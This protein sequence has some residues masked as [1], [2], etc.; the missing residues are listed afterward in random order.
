MS[1]VA[2]PSENKSGPVPAVLVGDP[3]VT[4]RGV[5]V[6]Q[7]WWGMN[8]QIQDEAKQIAAMGPFV[9][10]VPDLYRGKVATDNEHA[11][12]LMSNLDWP[13]AVKDI[14]ACVRYLRQRG[15]TK[16]GVTGFCMGGALTLAAA[17][18]VPGVDAAAPFYGIPSPDLCDVSKIAVPVQCH[19]GDND[20]V[21]GFS[22]PESQEKLK[23]KL[24]CQYEFHVYK[25]AGHAFTNETGPNYHP[26]NCKLSFQRLVKFFQTHL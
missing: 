17:A 21:M 20:Q 1:K 9:A 10:I 4:K 13:G 16:V 8:K 23:K 14:E 18:L 26:E 22:D 25:G 11:N 19:F 24:K 5:V 3:S 7:E 2:V 6:L 15:C 12:H